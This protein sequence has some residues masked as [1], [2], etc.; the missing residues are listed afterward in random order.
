MNH[1]FF[2]DNPASRWAFQDTQEFQVTKEFQVTVEFQVTQASQKT[3]AFQKILEFHVTQESQD[4][5][6]LS[7]FCIYPPKS[8][9]LTS[10]NEAV[11]LI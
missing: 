2:Y 1:H 6:R 9:L 11:A 10:Q 4:I 5:D 7:S 3:W 8:P